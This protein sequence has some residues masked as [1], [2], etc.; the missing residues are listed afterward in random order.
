MPPN[1]GLGLS[2]VISIIQQHPALLLST[3]HP[4]RFTYLSQISTIFETVDISWCAD[5][6]SHE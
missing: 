3:Y 5:M 2:L 1:H 6:F 4:E